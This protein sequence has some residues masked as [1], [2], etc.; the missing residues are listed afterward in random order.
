[1][2]PKREPTKLG[3]FLVARLNDHHINQE[4]FA[5]ALNIDHTLFPKWKV[6]NGLPSIEAIDLMA[7]ADLKFPIVRET[8][9][10]LSHAHAHR[11]VELYLE[12]LGLQLAARI[13]VVAKG[14][15]QTATQRIDASAAETAWFRFVTGQYYTLLSQLG[16]HFLPADGMVPGAATPQD[17]P[18]SS[19]DDPP[20]VPL[21]GTEQ[22]AQTEQTEKERTARLAN[23]GELFLV[24]LLSQFKLFAPTYLA[25]TEAPSWRVAIITPC[26]TRDFIC[27]KWHEGLGSHA[28]RQNRFYIGKEPD[29]EDPKPGIAGTV[30]LEEESLVFPPDVTT[31]P[32]Y[33]DCYGGKRKR[34]E[35]DYNSMVDL[36]IYVPD[37]S[38]P[39]GKN[40]FG[41]LSV[42][43]KS[44]E[45][46]KR[47]CQLLQPFADLCG[48]CI[49][50]TRLD[51][52]SRDHRTRR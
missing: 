51:Y 15:A 9:K 36:P 16:G 29:E 42:D 24:T 48:L 50:I 17:D 27:I 39:T 11:L 13:E 37:P 31:D 25:T 47:D 18:K 38:K 40:M 35:I 34:H 52:L 22:T 44:Y 7:T 32:L 2:R 6:G 28:E 43:S 49:H 10:F 41:V 20:G 45:F 23:I 1:V 19:V 30:F 8:T 12:A 14:D 4:Q 3:A 46:T 26:T 5:A 21:Q 33:K